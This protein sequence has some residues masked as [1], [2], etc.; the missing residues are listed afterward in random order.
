MGQDAE[1]WEGEHMS[2]PAGLRPLPPLHY[3]AVGNHRHV[4]GLA[5]EHGCRLVKADAEPWGYWLSQGNLLCWYPSLDGVR[6]ALM[7]GDVPR[8]R[9]WR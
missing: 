8:G 7:C 5:A 9:L 2:A 6:A 1:A 4:R 3:G